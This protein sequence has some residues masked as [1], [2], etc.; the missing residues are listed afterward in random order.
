MT[1]ASG[2]GR[3]YSFS[4]L[5]TSSLHL[6]HHQT[7]LASG[8]VF[9]L[10]L[11]QVMSRYYFTFQLKLNMLSFLEHHSSALIHLLSKTLAYLNL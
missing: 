9:S 11:G 2:V 5:G 4:M 3:G 6:G 7:L 1:M 10:H 8:L